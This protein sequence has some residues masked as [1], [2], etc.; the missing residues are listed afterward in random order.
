M[1]QTRLAATLREALRTRDKAAVAALRSAL[2][3][4]ANAEAVSPLPARA[5][6]ASSEHI[7]GAAP[8]LRAAE[9]P[10]RQLSEE[11]VTQ[12]VRREITERQEAAGQYAGAGHHERAARLRTEAEVLLAALDA[13]A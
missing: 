12:V 5:N 11:E 3:A 6:R 2:A 9:V 4:I 7:A 10:R 13:A 8:G 1:R